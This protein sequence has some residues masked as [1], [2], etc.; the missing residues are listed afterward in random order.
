MRREFLRRW[1]LNKHI[2]YLLGSTFVLLLVACAGPS[3]NRA[4]SGINAMPALWKAQSNSSTVYLFGSV[5][6]LP[7]EVKWYGPE[8]KKAFVESKVVA[9]ESVAD[10]SENRQEE[11]D[12]KNGFLPKGKEIKDY[13]TKDEY[14]HYMDIV[15]VLKIR[16]EKAKRMQPWLFTWLA[17]S[18]VSQRA[19]SYGVDNL[20][21][22]EAQRSGKSIQALETTK[23][24]I[25]SLGAE[26][27]SSQI[28][29][30]KKLLAKPADS[31]KKEK[32]KE[33]ENQSLLLSWMHGDIKKTASLVRK[34]MPASQYR[35][36]IV[37]RN[38]L[39]YPK[40]KQY[41]KKKYTTMVVVGQAHLIGKDSVLKMLKKDGYKVSRVQ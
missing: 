27:L 13:L 41:L 36:L 30:L 11:I 22:N 38:R 23:Q 31:N 28:K 16:P 20:L 15:H 32:E 5:H 34:Q 35:N 2:K 18:A 19:F 6:A 1:S 21:Q 12:M 17:R 8:I 10:E 7:A 33:K 40:I 26:P 24:A 3:L 29:G 9:F 25:N 39:W 14:A 4:A 37:K